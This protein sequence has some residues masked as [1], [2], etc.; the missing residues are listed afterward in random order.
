MRQ[1]TEVNVTQELPIDSTTWTA[2]ESLPTLPII[3]L[4]IGDALHS[5]NTS[6]QQIAEL[7]RA[8]PATSAKLLRLVNSSYFGIPGG[9]ADVS[10]AI[11]FVGF[12]TLYQ[13]VLS[14][15]V[16][17]TLGKPTAASDAR[18]LWLHSLTVATA[19]RELANE[20]HFSDAGTC[21]TAGLLHDMGKIALAKVQPIELGAAFEA[22]RRD[23]ISLEEAERKFNVAP[24]DS[25]G[26]RLA[27][28]WRFP[29]TLATPIEA[30]HTI[31]Q[32]DKAARLSPQLRTISEVVAA[33][34]HLSHVCSSSFGQPNIGEDGDSS[35]PELFDRNGLTEAQRTGLCDRTR[36]ALEKSQVFLSV[37]DS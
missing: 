5:K 8:D 25:L 17:E 28:R 20:I 21:F 16:L 19:A 13:L 15:S 18:T 6:V 7:L 24:H 2:L 35:A 33:A 29:A 12:H 11:P 14:I 9:V 34:D 31:H 10:R 23:G 37:L 32:K 30:H 3:A 26:S 36:R 22:V 1:W 27:R 4:Q